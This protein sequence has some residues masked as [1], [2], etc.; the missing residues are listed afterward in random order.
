MYIQY[1]SSGSGPVAL[2]AGPYENARW[3]R[4]ALVEAGYVDLIP[5]GRR[6]VKWVNK[7]PGKRAEFAIQ[8][9]KDGRA[10]IVRYPDLRRLDYRT[11]SDAER[12]EQGIRSS[13]KGRGRKGPRA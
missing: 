7:D 3:A 13:L 2:K 10:K 8:I 11:S 4:T 9:L 6:P 1:Y 5:Q 12:G